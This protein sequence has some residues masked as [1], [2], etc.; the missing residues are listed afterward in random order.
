MRFWVALCSAILL[1]ILLG[2]C[3]TPSEGSRGHGDSYNYNPSPFWER[4]S[5]RD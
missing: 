2:A 3:K 5:Q 1:S 4:N